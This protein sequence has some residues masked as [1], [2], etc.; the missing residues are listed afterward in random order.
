MRRVVAREHTGLL[1]DET[2][3]AYENGFKGADTSPQAPNVLVATPTLEMGIDIGDL[4]AVFLSS[5][6]RTVAAYLQRVGRA[7]RLTGNA[8]NLAYLTGRGEQLPKLGEPLSV[9]NGEVRPPATYLRAEEI[10]RRQY[11]AHLV[12]EFARDPQRQHPRSAVG[13]IGSSEPG[14]FL[15]D[16]I[17]HAEDRRRGA[18]SPASPPRSTPSPTPIVDALRELARAR[19]RARDQRLRPAPA[20]GERPLADGRWRPCSTASTAIDAVLPELI[21]QGRVAGR[22]RRRPA[23]AALGADRPQAHPS[24]SSRTCAASTGSGCSR[25]TACCPTTRCS[26]TAS[27][28][29]SG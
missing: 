17:A 24:A 19:R 25:S 16:L 27:P 6:P 7:G 22:H 23:R 4:S 3:L 2:R 14:T 18:T 5:L 1:D 13:A 29:T 10:L 26:T 9:I 12:D 21:D 28:S 8:L 11:T 15:G 20:R